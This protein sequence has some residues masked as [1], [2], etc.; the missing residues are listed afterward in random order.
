[1]TLL[2]L[3]DSEEVAS[4]DPLYLRMIKH[5]LP[6]TQTWSLTIEKTLRDFF[7]GISRAPADART[8]IDNV[9]LDFFPSTT[10]EL[11]TW[12]KQ[13]G[14]D[15]SLA[16]DDRRSRLSAAW[17]ATGGQSPKYLQDVLRNSGFDVYVHECWS[18]PHVAYDPRSYTTAAKVG[19]V[20]CHEPLAECGEPTA[21]CN[22][23]LANYTGYIVNLDL[24]N[25]APPPIPADSSK[26][27]YFVYIGAATFP[28][29]ANIP[30]AQRAE[31]ERILLKYF[32]AR[33]W[34]VTL[35]NY[36]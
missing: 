7:V 21:Q 13:F 11:E 12:E 36:V 24:T 4:P 28:N 9:Y 18:S 27:P 32:P 1:M 33:H 34:I 30:S 25:R 2:L 6:I 29:H 10:R 20:Q 26:W 14:Y 3:L 15:G 17:Q 19:I 23:F 35:I 8:F 5:L 31:F 16:G 22:G